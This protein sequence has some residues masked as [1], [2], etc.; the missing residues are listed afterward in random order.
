[1]R[2]IECQ[3]AVM[4]NTAGSALFRIGN[5]KV[6]AF[7]HGPHQ[8]TQRQGQT[9]A[10]GVAGTSTRGILNVNFF[11]TNF[12]AVDHRADIKTDK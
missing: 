3:L 4:P 12:S 6:V 5:T 8:I 1:M 11:I 7:L 10:Q 2:D 9:G